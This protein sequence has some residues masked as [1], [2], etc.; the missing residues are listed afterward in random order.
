MSLKLFIW[1]KI[2]KIA[3]NTFTKTKLFAIAAF[4]VRLVIILKTQIMLYACSV[5][6]YVYVDID[7][8][9]NKYKSDIDCLILQNVPWVPHAIAN[10]EDEESKSMDA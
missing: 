1:G 2:N 4:N 7:M 3:F 6:T 9:T 10:V 5:Q 8:Y